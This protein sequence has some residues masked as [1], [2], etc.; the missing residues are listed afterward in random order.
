MTS[1]ART[2]GSSFD[3]DLFDSVQQAIV[4]QLGGN[5]D[6]PDLEAHITGEAAQTEDEQSLLN[7][8]FCSEL[9]AHPI[10]PLYV[11]SLM[12]M[13]ERE[14]TKFESAETDPGDR[15]RI[16]WQAWKGV[17]TEILGHIESGA[18]YYRSSLK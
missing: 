4:E 12:K 8:Q 5:S 1:K 11:K 7:A 2:Q 17:V 16:R 9:V 10:Y 18:E 13:V 6:T 15:L 3:P 14:H